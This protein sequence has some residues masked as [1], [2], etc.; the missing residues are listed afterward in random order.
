M[1]FSIV[2]IQSQSPNSGIVIGYLELLGLSE[3][4]VE[5]F[6]RKDELQVFKNQKEIF[7]AE[8]VERSILGQR[9]LNKFVWYQLTMGLDEHLCVEYL[10][11]S[12]TYLK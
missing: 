2:L 1:C 11:H 6:H 10:A 12:S 8:K 4:K 7:V 5:I 9:K 3:V